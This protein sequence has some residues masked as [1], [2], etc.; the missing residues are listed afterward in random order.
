M[1]IFGDEFKISAQKQFFLRF[2]NKEKIRSMDYLTTFILFQ[3][4]LACAF[5][6]W[7]FVYCMLRYVKW[8]AI[9]NDLSLVNTEITPAVG[10]MYFTFFYASIFINLF[11]IG[12]KALIQC[13]LMDEEMF[14]GDQKFAEQFIKEFMDEYQLMLKKDEELRKKRDRF[15]KGMILKIAPRRKKTQALE[16][17]KKLEEEE[18]EDDDDS[19]GSDKLREGKGQ[20]SDEDLSEE[21]DED[22]ESEEDEDEDDDDEDE[23]EEEEE[24]EDDEDDEFEDSDIDASHDDGRSN[25]NSQGSARPLNPQK[26]RVKTPD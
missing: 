11:D 9:D 18:E 24:E 3:M 16:E 22:E 6:A 26:M 1:A 7:S 17:Q 14:M 19:E 2:R 5:I 12:T 8:S 10:I 20:I 4:K 15:F 23:E 21:D 25:L 13:Y